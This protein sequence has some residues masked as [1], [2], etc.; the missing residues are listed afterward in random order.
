MNWFIFQLTLCREHSIKE[1][2][3][4]YEVSTVWFGLLRVAR[5]TFTPKCYLENICVDK[6]LRKPTGSETKTSE[7]FFLALVGQLYIKTPVNAM[8]RS[9]RF[10]QSQNI[11]LMSWL[12]IRG[13]SLCSEPK[14]GQIIFSRKLRLN[15]FECHIINN[16]RVI[17]SIEY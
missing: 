6:D 16:S 15:R 2:I 8:K 5:T 9:S 11:K 12:P 14:R 10:C 7:L 3:L 13:M 17:F 4:D 1:P